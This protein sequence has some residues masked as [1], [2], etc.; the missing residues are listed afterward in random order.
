MANKQSLQVKSIKEFKNAKI[1]NI[2]DTFLLL[3][4]SAN[5]NLDAHN[6]DHDDGDYDLDDAELH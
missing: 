2:E 3:R 5:D 1:S 4:L 6:D